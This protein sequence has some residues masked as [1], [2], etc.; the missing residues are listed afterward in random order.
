MQHHCL[1]E[2]RTLLLWIGIVWFLGWG[3]TDTLGQSFWDPPVMLSPSQP[4]A[5]DFT[6][7]PTLI[8]ANP[9]GQTSTL[10]WGAQGHTWRWD[11]NRWHYQGR[12]GN[13]NT[14][15]FTI[16]GMVPNT[17]RMHYRAD[18][19][20]VSACT[21]TSC[22]LQGRNCGTIPDGC[23]GTLFC[24][25]CSAG[26][27]CGGGGIIGVCGSSPAAATCTPGTW[28]LSTVDSAGDVGRSS[29][30]AV[31]SS[32]TIHIVYYDVDNHRLKHASKSPSTR[33]SIETV[34]QGT[35]T[36]SFAQTSMALDFSGG[37]HV[38]YQRRIT[39]NNEELRYVYRSPA[40]GW[41][42]P[43]TLDAGGKT[44]YGSDIIADSNGGLHISYERLYS[45]EIRYLYKPQ[46][47]NW[48]NS[49]FVGR[50]FGDTAL[51]VDPGGRRHFS[52]TN[53]NGL[54]YRVRESNGNWRTEERVSNVLQPTNK[55]LQ[56]DN[57][58]GVHLAFNRYGQTAID[59]AYRTPGNPPTGGIWSQRTLDQSSVGYYVA[60]V[61]DNSGRIHIAYQDDLNDD[62][63]YVGSSPQGTWNSPVVVDAQG[64][65]AN[66]DISLASLSGQ[67]YVSYYD[68]THEDIKIAI[69]CP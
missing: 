4:N 56:L 22:Q 39:N 9:R 31:E 19:V 63:K 10:S 61:L 59:H 11:G 55:D 21:P 53:Y 8:Y 66:Y 34:V 30:I 7:R 2:S 18:L 33:W 60:M 43:L 40:T 35:N 14:N 64:Q 47:G 23:G 50:G 6:S 3:I 49:E 5:M 44:G 27:S 24:G 58:N 41:S 13:L 57:Q 51:V 17:S 45:G 36:E 15:S 68:W 62:L 32:G 54:F 65:V 52:Y 69:G 48:Q 12:S 20:P 28:D 26:T 16:I 46:S 1:T 42:T 67:V 29:S 37:L 25:S 38:S